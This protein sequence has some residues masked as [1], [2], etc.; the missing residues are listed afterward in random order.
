MP[1]EPIGLISGLGQRVGVEGPDRVRPSRA[2]VNL[3]EWLCTTY[4]QPARVLTRRRTRY[5]QVVLGVG[6]KHVGRNRSQNGLDGGLV[7]PLA[8]DIVK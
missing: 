3:A 1:S 5:G 6:S 4:P 2:Y 8:A 7:E